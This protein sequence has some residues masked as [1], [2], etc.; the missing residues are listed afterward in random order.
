MPRQTPNNALMS[1]LNDSGLL[2]SSNIPVHDAPVTASAREHPLVHRVP[3]HTARL[4]LVTTECLELLL[5]VSD[6]KQFEQVIS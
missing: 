3:L 6:I 1:S 5:Q 2:L 4:L